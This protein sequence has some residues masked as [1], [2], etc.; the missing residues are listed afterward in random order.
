M[1]LMDRM[2]LRSE[3]YLNPKTDQYVGFVVDS[4]SNKIC[5]ADEVQKL[6]LDD[7]KDTNNN[8]DDSAFSCSLHVNK[9]IIR[10][11]HNDTCTG[12]FSLTMVLCQVMK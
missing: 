8:S 4:T 7:E 11:T 2:K 6:L 1:I 5:L 9:F 3:F 12:E 10:L